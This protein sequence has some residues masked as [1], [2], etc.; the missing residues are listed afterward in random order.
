MTLLGRCYRLLGDQPRA[1]ACAAEARRNFTALTPIRQKTPGSRA[2]ARKPRYAISVIVPSYNRLPIL[3]KCLAALEA[4]SV[5]PKD[6]EV[7]VI[8]DGSSDGTQQTMHAYRPPFH[9]QYLYQDN[10]GT[11]TARNNG[12]QHATGEYLLLMNDDTICDPDALEQHLKLQRELSS[13]RWALLG[14]FEYPEAAHKR[15]LSHFLKVGIFMFPQ[16]EMEAGCPYP[17]SHF[18]TCNLSI[19]REAVLAVGSFD[20]T[21]KLSEDTEIGIR[22]LEAGYGV[23]YHPA[24]HAW[25]DHLPYQ[26]AN[27][28]R[29]ARVYG[30]DYFYMFRRHP[31]VVREWGM[32]MDIG[33]LSPAILPRIEEYLMRNR[34]EV[35]VAV[36]ELQRW[37]TIDFEPVLA[38][39]QKSSRVLERFRTLVPTIHWFYLLESMRDTVL[40]E[41]AVSVS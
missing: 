18:I 24:A 5:S 21:Y 31:R 17:Y 26:C 28:I 39:S 2:L 10:S 25:H 40:R 29:R 35:E 33:D 32:P 6:F 13:E 15:A 14:N 19:R 37:D 11:G 1:S 3:R 36:A 8:D 38:D 41:F 4:Q 22:L 34:S 27:L 12:V 23:L 9:F 30:A 20:G 7:V 16:A